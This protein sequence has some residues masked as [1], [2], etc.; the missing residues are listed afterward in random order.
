[1]SKPISTPDRTELAILNGSL[2][3]AILGAN[4]GYKQVSYAIS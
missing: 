2:D 3:V 1:M 4:S